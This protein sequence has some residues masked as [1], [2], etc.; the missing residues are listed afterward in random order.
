[1]ES[2]FFPDWKKKKKV[3][4]LLIRFYGVGFCSVDFGQIHLRSYFKKDQWKCLSVFVGTQQYQAIL[5]FSH[6]TPWTTAKTRRLVPYYPINWPSKRASATQWRNAN[7]THL[8]QSRL[9]GLYS[10]CDRYCCPSTVYWSC[11]FDLRR[12]PSRFQTTNCNVTVER[13]GSWN[14]FWES[15]RERMDWRSAKGMLKQQRKRARLLADLKLARKL[16]S[17][18]RRQLMVDVTQVMRQH[19]PAGGT[20]PWAE[21]RHGWRLEWNAHS[22]N[23]IGK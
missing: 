8:Y 9:G 22:S 17:L 12:S 10:G 2:F 11:P 21:L 23:S 14:H 1:M 4:Q 18:A 16:Y 13:Q 19:T 7:L 20:F 15:E 6:A 3:K 5:F